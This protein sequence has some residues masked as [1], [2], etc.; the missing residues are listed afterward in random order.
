MFILTWLLFI[1]GNIDALSLARVYNYEFFEINA[2]SLS[3][4]AIGGSSG[5][6]IFYASY[7]TSFMPPNEDAFVYKQDYRFM[8][9]RSVNEINVYVGIV[10]SMATTVGDL[11]ISQPYWGVQTEISSPFIL[12]FP[13]HPLRVS[14]IFSPRIGVSY[15]PVIGWGKRYR[16]ELKNVL[17]FYFKTLAAV[18]IGK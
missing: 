12:N 5:S 4:A 6:W 14:F 2:A 1:G 7:G 9:G 16:K 11:Y 17:R 8:I 3:E 15:Y 13:M 18:G 10:S